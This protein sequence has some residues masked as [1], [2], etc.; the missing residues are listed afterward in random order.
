MEDIL[1]IDEDVEFDKSI[2]RQQHYVISP[3]TGT[4][5]DRLSQIILEFNNLNVST[6]PADSSLYLEGTFL[7]T[8]NKAAVKNSKISNNGFAFL[9]DEARYEVH[10]VEIDRTRNVGVT[11]TMKNYVSLS[12]SESA[13]MVNAGWDPEFDYGS[14]VGADGHFSVCIPLKNIFGFAEDYNRVLVHAR[15]QIIL[16]RAS[17][18]KNCYEIKD[19]TKAE[20]ECTITL[21]HVSWRLPFVQPAPKHNLEILHKVE[22]GKTIRIPYRNWELF[23]F[24]MLPTS[25]SQVWSIKSTT[26]LE[27]PRYVIVGFQTDRKAK[28]KKSASEFDHCDLSDI[29]LYINEQ[30]YPYE[31]L[32]IN[33]AKSHFS[34]LYDM[35]ARFRKSYYGK[36]IKPIVQP[37]VFKSRAPLAV[38]D[39]SK[40]NDTLKSG[41]VNFRLEFKAENPFPASTSAFAL[42]IHDRILDYNL[43]NNHV[44]KL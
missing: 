35:F 16:L 26:E 30:V 43:L 27:K 31:N 40:Q 14:C 11:S 39:C 10:G 41:P 17:D 38:I 20:E 32:N 2:E 24:P 4:N 25:A 44:T 29:K 28:I 21:T 9:F 15:Q 34:I 37:S 8:A 7:D 12:P 18:D 5:F 13:A 36:G 1:N 22:K 42:V 33:F 23:E 6:L 19:P 3:Q